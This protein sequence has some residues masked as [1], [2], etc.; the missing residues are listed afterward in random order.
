MD[1][2]LWALEY[3]SGYSYGSDNEQNSNSR[4]WLYFQRWNNFWFP[5]A[6]ADGKRIIYSNNIL[7]IF[8]TNLWNKTRWPWNYY[9]NGTFICRNNFPFQWDNEN[10]INLWWWSWETQNKANLD[11]DKQWPCPEWYH[12][13]SR[14]ERSAAENLFTLWQNTIWWME[15]CTS[16]H[17]ENT[18]IIYCMP[19]ILWLPFPGYMGRNNWST[20]NWIGTY[21]DYWSANS[22]S[23]GYAYIDFFHRTLISPKN[24]PWEQSYGL[25]LRCFKNT[26]DLILSFDSNGWSNVPSKTGFKRWNPITSTLYKPTNP[27]KTWSTFA[28]WYTDTWYTQ[29]FIFSGNTYISEDTTLYA[30]WTCNSWYIESLDGQSC[31]K[32]N[33]ATFNTSWVITSWT[34]TKSCTIHDNNIQSCDITAPNLTGYV[35]LWRSTNSSS[36][37]AEYNV[38]DI[39]SLTWDMTYYAITSPAIEFTWSTPANHTTQVENYFTSQIDIT[40]SN[41][42]GFS[43]VLDGNE[44]SLYDDSLVLMYNFDNVESLWESETIVKDLS[45]YGNDGIVR[46][47]ATP[48]VWK[49]NTWY[50]FPGNSY[51]NAWNNPSLFMDEELTISLWVKFLNLDYENRSWYLQTFVKKWHPDAAAGT[52]IPHSWFWFSYDNRRKRNDSYFNY[53]CF[54]NSTWG[55]AGWWNNLGHISYKFDNYER[56]H[57]TLTVWDLLAK[58]YINGVYIWEKS[59]LN[60]NLWNSIDNLIVWPSSSYWS[61]IVLDE[62]YIYNRALS[63]EEIDTLYHSNL[64]KTALNKWTYTIGFTWL[65]GG[66]HTYGWIMSDI[67]WNKSVS[68]AINIC[69]TWYHTEDGTTCV[70]NTKTVTCDYSWVP[71][72]ANYTTWDSIQITW[73][74]TWNTWEWPQI[75]SCPWSCEIWYTKSPD[76][77]SCLSNVLPYTVNHYQQNT[78]D[79]G[80]TLFETENK[81]WLYDSLTQATS[82]TYQWFIAQPIE[83]QIIQWNDTHVDI[84]YDRNI[85][86]INIDLNGGTWPTSFTW[87]YGDTVVPPEITKSWYSIKKRVPALPETMPLNWFSSKPVRVLTDWSISIS[88]NPNKNTL[89]LSIR[90]TSNSSRELTWAFTNDYFTISDT[91]WEEN[92][93]HATLSIWNLVWNDNVNHIIPASN[94]QVKTDGIVRLSWAPSSEVWLTTTMTNWRTATWQVTYFTRWDIVIDDECKPWEYW[95]NLELK[96]TVPSYTIPDNYHWTITYTLYED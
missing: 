67:S 52:H 80:Y 6:D 16:L 13:P 78:W 44:I 93:Y 56:Y 69:T 77:Q 75:E 35:I 64:S 66:I 17:G 72:H 11:T 94:V 46:W 49:Y 8:V 95:I 32:H 26:P 3:S 59:L 27:T 38:W 37:T 19:A 89:D 22:K 29:E 36:N 4:I 7:N 74:G 10:D 60:L 53:T 88:V 34:I 71:A 90:G 50:Y 68:R 91:K 61:W 85:Y 58:L 42:S 1:R 24:Y 73:S 33:I 28:W 9:F 18:G 20:K 21:W 40:T 48:V 63:Q 96:I 5:N 39:I 2:N 12:V 55:A 41:L 25:S 82:K 65:A 57:L 43:S 23:D 62:I 14:Y 15:Y 81:T 86:T 70:E 47:Q 79:N 45:K 51:V 84:Y 54:W 87:K 76:G 92:G 83:Q 31:E 30:K